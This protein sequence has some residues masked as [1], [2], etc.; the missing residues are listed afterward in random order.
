[1]SHAWT[2]KN[3]DY[4]LAGRVSEL[5]RLQLQSRVREPGGRRLLQEIGGGRG[6]RALDV[7]CGVLGWLWVLSARA[8]SSPACQSAVFPIPGTPESTNTAGAASAR[9]RKSSID[10]LSASRPLSLPDVIRAHSERTP[11][12][13]CRD[14]DLSVATRP[15]L[16][17]RP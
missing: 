3:D 12:E 6:T 5:E 8:R 14:L 9:A 13:N 10:R 11:G 17:S 2:S 16:G 7:G 4:L 15:G 1:M